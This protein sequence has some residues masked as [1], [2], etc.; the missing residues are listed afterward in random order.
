[1]PFIG[2]EEL[3]SGSLSRHQLRMSYRAVFPNVYVPTHAEVPL[4]L[5]IRAAW[6]WS[7]RRAVIGGAAAA[8]LHG[9]QWIPDNVPVELIHT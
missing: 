1:M 7:G 6:L 9:A 5:R 4:E 8:A 3:A 2:S